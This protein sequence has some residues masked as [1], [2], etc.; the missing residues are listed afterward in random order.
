[1]SAP[2]WMASPPEVHSALLSS[3]PGTGALLAAA[4]AWTTLSTEYAS[5]AGELS[6][7]LGA[8]QAGSWQGLSAEQYVAAHAPY[9]VW[10]TQASANSAGAAAQHE[11]SA[12]AYTTALAAMPTLAELA[13]NHTIHAV[14]VATNFFGINTIPI[15]LNEADYV[16]MW[17]QAATT[18]ATYQVVAGTALASA[19][20]TTPAPILLAPGVGEAGNAA[21]SA[22]QTGAQA[23]ATQSGSSLNLS[24]VWS[25][26]LNFMQ[27]PFGTIQQVLG[28]FAANP[29][30]ALVAYGPMLFL[31]GAFAAYEVISPIVTY[32]PMLALALP[33]VLGLGINYLLSLAAPV[34]AVD[35]PAAAGSTPGIALAAARQPT[36]SPLAGIALTV[37]APAPISAPASAPAATGASAAPV[38]APAAPVFAYLMGGV[39]AED[40]PGPTLT[41]RGGSKAPASRIPAAAAVGLSRRDRS[42]AR[43]RRRVTQRAYGD[44]FADM[45]FDVDPD[46][47]GPPAEEPV[48]A[49]TAS[50]TGVRSLGF[51]GTARKEAVAE[52][53]GL[54]TLAGDG[55]GGGPTVPMVPG[56]WDHD[57][58]DEVGGGDRS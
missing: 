12:A 17:I 48:A 43:R 53:V 16:R 55:F 26:L 54:T 32:V 41:G 23:Q 21:A 50:D 28:L 35:I 3:G 27:N 29:L 18:M 57:R 7:L 10:L 20:R 5:A 39:D 56:T 37:A 33:L 14:L 22:S 8:V 47:G 11:A 42:R 2:I 40:G 58:V 19:P 52:V 34:A 49:T 38:A 31:L 15:A 6:E 30:A 13:A 51:V 36:A 44:E 9:L 25:Q 45:N 24:D 4:G 46:W 1:M